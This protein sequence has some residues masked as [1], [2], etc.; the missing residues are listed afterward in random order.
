M[1]VVA[2]IGVL[3]AVALPAYQN[4]TRQATFIE[5]ISAVA[6][7]KVP[8]EMRVQTRTSAAIN[9]TGISTGTTGLPAAIVQ[10]S[11]AHG[12]S[13][14]DG[15]ITGIWMTD[16]TTMENRTYILTPTANASSVLN[17]TVSGTCQATAL[18]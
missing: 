5:L 6:S 18:C 11:T 2:I 17:W 12:V 8:I 16:S 14:T 10:S 4:Y 13:A 15:V 3:A 9:F 7:L 1:I